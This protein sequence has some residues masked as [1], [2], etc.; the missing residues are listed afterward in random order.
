MLAVMMRDMFSRVGSQEVGKLISI[1]RLK[2]KY[3]YIF[4]NVIKKFNK[5]KE[6]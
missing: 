6:K 2:M 1:A 4:Y 5:E 3:A